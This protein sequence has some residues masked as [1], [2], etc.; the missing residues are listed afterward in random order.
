M[1]N[2]LKSK[3]HLNIITNTRDHSKNKNKKNFKNEVKKYNENAD[4][5]ETSIISNDENTIEK[6]LELKSK[7]LSIIS[8]REKELKNNR[9]RRMNKQLIAKKSELDEYNAR[10]Y[11]NKN[12]NIY[13][14]EK[15]KISKINNAMDNMQK[16][17]LTSSRSSFVKSTLKP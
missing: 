10:L 12:V 4:K 6:M 14:Y 17:M 8:K 2:H 15:N 11:N 9:K 16:N 1:E 7:A 5:V 13:N 3:K